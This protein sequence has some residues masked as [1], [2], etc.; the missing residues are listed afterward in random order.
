MRFFSPDYNVQDNIWYGDQLRID[1]YPDAVI[2]DTN[3]LAMIGYVNAFVRLSRYLDG[4][5]P[6]ETYRVGP[7]DSS[8]I[9]PLGINMTVE[10]RGNRPGAAIHVTNIWAGMHREGKNGYTDMVIDSGTITGAVGTPP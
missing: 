2:T 8:F 9:P 7:S 5:F 6:N 1:L 4:N 10:K 3:Q